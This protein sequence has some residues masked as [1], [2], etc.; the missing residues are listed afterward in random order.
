MNIIH[1]DFL[2]QVNSTFP[3]IAEELTRNTSEIFQFVFIYI[4]F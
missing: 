4:Y 3:S 1:I 2:L